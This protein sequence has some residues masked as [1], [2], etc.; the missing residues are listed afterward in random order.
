MANFERWVT[1]N[2]ISHETKQEIRTLIEQEYLRKMLSYY[3]ESKLNLLSEH[4]C[5]SFKINLK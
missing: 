2:N 5:N 1:V 3:M 4:L